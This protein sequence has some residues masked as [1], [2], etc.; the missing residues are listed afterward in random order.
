M[1]EAYGGEDTQTYPFGRVKTRAH[2]IANVYND[3]DTRCRVVVTGEIQPVAPSSLKDYAATVQVGHSTANGTPAEWQDFPGAIFNYNAWVGRSTHTF[4]V[5]RGSRDTEISCWCKYWG[6]AHSGRGAA[7]NRG[8]LFVPVT[9]PAKPATPATPSNVGPVPKPSSITP[10]TDATG[11]SVLLYVAKPSTST[12]NNVRSIEVERKGSSESSYTRIGTISGSYGYVYDTSTGAGQTYY[13]RARYIGNDGR[14]GEYLETTVSNTP[15]IA[16][17]SASLQANNAVY[18]D[19]ERAGNDPAVTLTTRVKVEREV[20]GSGTWVVV[21]DSATLEGYTDTLPTGTKTVRYRVSGK[22][23]TSGY[24]KPITTE[25]YTALR[26]PSKPQVTT[27]PAGSCAQNGAIV[28]SWTPNHPD[29]TAQRQAQV[30]YKVV[31]A[32]TPT[33]AN[34]PLVRTITGGATET[35][36]QGTITA[37][38]GYVDVCVR[39]LGTHADWGAWSDYVRVKIVKAPKLDITSSSWKIQTYP[40]VFT[41]TSTTLDVLPPS[42]NVEITHQTRGKLYTT[43][44]PKGKPRIELTAATAQLKSGE[45]YTL[46]AYGTSTDGFAFSVAKTITAQFLAPTAPIC[47][48]D[49]QTDEFVNVLHIHPTEEIVRRAGDTNVYRVEDTHAGEA[50]PAFVVVKKNAAS[51]TE[52][53]E[54]TFT[55][56]KGVTSTLTIPPNGAYNAGVIIRATGHIYRIKSDKTQEDSPYTVNVPNYATNGLRIAQDGVFTVT[57]KVSG[58]NCQVLPNPTPS[59]YHIVKRVLA[60]GTTHTIEDYVLP[61]QGAI[62]WFP[63]LNAD[64]RYEITSVSETGAVGVSYKNVRVES[65]SVALS[66]GKGGKYV[67]QL[68]GNLT[69]SEKTSKGYELYTFADGGANKGLPVLYGTD[70]L[71]KTHELTADNVDLEQ[72]TRLRAYAEQY[73]RCWVRDLYGSRWLCACSFSFDTSVPYDLW[74]VSITLTETVFEEP[75]R[76]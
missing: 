18:V 11:G 19:F 65:S 20:N 69:W 23:T 67:E 63:P 30:K 35:T 74:H 58:G 26:A 41:L 5:N 13:Y 64:F 6:S 62:D 75:K 73:G 38:L 70:T 60:D 28:V 29:G 21:T 15:K 3:S 2:V 14:Q 72:M 68:F 51:Y 7:F 9:I 37:N 10:V 27:R 36:L 55:N 24:S 32:A 4:Y 59:K 8:E 48:I 33:T 34:T 12:V 50:V 71:T 66:F 43:T 56:V 54:L 49:V 22:T 61:N 53:L 76:E 17:A 47:D 1:A 46:R 45:T 44:V 40:H 39:T 52:S 25:T 57:A 31:Q 16:S 42:I